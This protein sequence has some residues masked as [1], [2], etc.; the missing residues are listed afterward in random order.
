MLKKT[1]VNVGEWMG[2][3]M[4]P[5]FFVLM[6]AVALSAC[7]SESPGVSKT[8]DPERD[9][10]AAAQTSVETVTIYRDKYGT[11]QV[12][13]DSNYGVY[14]GYGYAV[15]TDR[16][17]QM[18][19]LRR[20][21]EGR[22]AEV[23][24]SKYLD[25]DIHV[26]TAYDHR[27][28]HRQL[29]QINAQDREIL[30]A[31]AAGFSERV[32]EVLD[33]QA[34]LLPKEFADFGF[35]PE[36]WSSYDVAMIFIG[37]IIHRYSDFNSELDSLSLLS[38]LTELHGLDKAQKIFDASKWLLDPS[39]PTTVP[40]KDSAAVAI[41]QG[42][43]AKPVLDEVYTKRVVL[44]EN[45]KFLGTS[46]NPQVQ[47][48]AQAQI[49]EYGYI[50]PEYQAASNFWS[51]AGSKLSD[52][53][54]ALVN[55]PQFDFGLPSYVYGIGLHGGDFNVVGNTLLGLPTLLFAHNNHVSW[56]STAGMSDQVDVFRE[57]LVS[58][59]PEHY[60]HD[61]QHKKFE[62]WVETI[63]VKGADS[64]ESLARRS[65]HGMVL[66][67][68]ADKGIAY[69][70]ARAWEGA[71]VETLIAWVNLAKDKTMDAVQSRL[72][73]VAA[74]INF[75][76]MDV[77]GNLGY[78]HGGRYPLRADSQDSRLPSDG[79]G[80]EDWLGFAPYSDNPNVRNPD[81]G[82]IV[83]WNNRPAAGWLASDLWTYTWSKADRSKHIVEELSSPQPMTANDVWA[84]AERISYDD[85]SATFLLPYLKQAMSNSVKNSAAHKAFEIVENWDREWRLEEN[86]NYGAA[87]LIIEHWTKR[88]FNSVLKDDIGEAKYAMYAAT[89]NPSSP[90]GASM[91]SS[92]GAKVILRNLDSLANGADSYDF[93]NGVEPAVVLAQSFSETI[94]ALSKEHGDD[95]SLWSI[96]PAPMTW[97]PYNFRGVPQASEDALV[98]LP[99]Y[100]NRGSENNFFIARDGKFLAYDVIPPGQSGFI[101]LD[102]TASAHNNDQMELYSKFETKVIPFSIEQVKATATQTKV[103]DI[104]QPKAALQPSD[105]EASPDLENVV[106]RMQSALQRAEINKGLGAFIYIDEAGVLA[107]ARV[108]QDAAEAGKQLGALHGIP[109]V[110]KD[111]THVAGMPNSAGTPSL[112]SFVPQLNNPAVQR[113]LDAGAI[114]LGKSNMHELAFGIT[115]NNAA[116]GPV[117]NARDSSRIAGGSSGGTAA[118]VAAGIVDMGLGTDTG[119]ST[120]IPPALNGVVGFRPTIGR[121][122]SGGVTP[123]SE[124]RDTVGPIA[125]N[126]TNTALLDCVMSDCKSALKSVELKGLR[127]GIPREYF[128]HNLSADVATV[129]QQTIDRLTDAGAVMIN[130]DM[131]GLEDLNNG[132]SF[133]VVLY[134]FI[135]E[136]P[137][138]LDSQATGVSMRQLVDA[139]ASPD[140]KTTVVSQLGEQAMP[141][142][143]YRQAIQEFRPALQSLYQKTFDDYD[144]AA[145]LMPTTV[146]TAQ[147]I[148]SSDEMVELNGVQV[149]TFPTYIRNT[150]PSSNAGIPSLT[151]PAGQDSDGLPIGILLDGPRD[152]DRQLLSIGLAIEKV[153]HQQSN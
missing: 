141:E 95:M 110:V 43:K 111:N 61:N 13:A 146:L 23:L 16:L 139:I 82:Y 31:Y 106:E 128:Y 24:G 55:G 132:V 97:K 123:V 148:I 81:Q 71:E 78:T 117:R 72:G 50:G 105:N 113:L 94:T 9:A 70:R 73:K 153:I 26:R 77:S 65:V 86:G 143:A 52:A 147:P 126:V 99:A 116:F 109:I 91:G 67:I 27:A 74:N 56:G 90:L 41:T 75:Y 142:Q 100:M 18:E 135:R 144:I 45:G 102:G 88:L 57:Q 64:V 114:V 59:K 131:P 8:P 19:M 5:S 51:V 60:L 33:Q 98:S 14:F 137:A 32:D 12:V 48:I 2:A 22:V 151:L 83:N 124:T 49:A 15:A 7:G 30:E 3:V 140:V 20:T 149:P 118:A 40:R 62:T 69:T 129:M 17:F 93:F 34:T 79:T 89:N 134:E 10:K 21:A 120:R 42:D 63:K 104:S 28:V 39:S 84:V 46:D 138:Y 108:A 125:N 80:S 68:D 150:D 133:P 103:V 127:L 47:V 44:D 76:Y 38:S 54:G 107:A 35:L 145:L 87:E 36:H 121:Y 66:S 101:A 136:L 115:S 29:Q 130:V 25:L 53:D 37:S 96:A 119:G 152:S 85:V 92:V 6:I 58:G 112:K 11:P 4:R 1:I 122:P